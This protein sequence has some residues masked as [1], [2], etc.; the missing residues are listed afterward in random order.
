MPRA[1]RTSECVLDGVIC[2]LDEAGQPSRELLDSGGG[3]VVYLVFD[4]LE[5]ETEPVIEEPW[6]AR[7]KLLEGLLDE[8]RRRGA[9]LTRLRRRQRAA[10]AAR[11]SRPRH[12]GQAPRLALPP[13]RVSDDWRLLG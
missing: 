4:L 5:L 11:G 13:G 7:R 12:R 1:L 6:K 10:Q 9:P 3:T 2:A 8:Q